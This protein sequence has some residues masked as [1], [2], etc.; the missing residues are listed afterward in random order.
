MKDFLLA[1]VVFICSL[2]TNNSCQETYI[3]RHHIGINAFPISILFM[4]KRIRRDKLQHGIYDFIHQKYN[5]EMD[6]F[7]HYIIIL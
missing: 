4:M 1:L 5:S 2:L 6:E 7:Q 3:Y